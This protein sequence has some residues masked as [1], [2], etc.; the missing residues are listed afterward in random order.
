[1]EQQILFLGAG[2]MATALAMGMV[3]NGFA[4][5]MIRAFD[6]SAS[7]ATAFSQ[8]TGVVAGDAE[9]DI[10]SRD[11]TTIIIAVKPQQLESA[12]SGKASLFRNKLVISIAAGV[13]LKKLEGLTGSSRVVRVMPNTPALIGAGMSAYS[14]TG[15]VTASD[16]VLTERILAATGRFC[17]VEEKLMNAVTGVSGSGPAYVFEFIQ[18]LADGGV[19]AG[20]PDEIALELAT[21]TVLGAAQLVIKSGL[22]PNELR[23]QV[24]SPGGTTLA[25]LE[26]LNTYGFRKTVV[27]AVL[28]AAA[29]SAELGE[30][31]N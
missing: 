18:A 4:P 21:Q 6:V 16:V 11:C 15:V 5:G 31:N 1:M 13:T 28:A 17:R 22:S 19:S 27:T 10:L 29:R 24:T 7:A 2:K 12:L 20:L 23:E 8:Q 30:T 3:K 14:I 9:T 26:T 25:A